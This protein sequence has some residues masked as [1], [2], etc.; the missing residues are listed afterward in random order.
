M[1]IYENKS[2]EQYS[3]KRI[4][5]EFIDF[6]RFKVENDTFT[7]GEM[8]SIA[9]AII[10][11]ADISATVDELSS[12]YGKSKDAVNGVIKRKMI[13]K[14]RRNVVLYSLSAFRK[15]IPDKWSHKIP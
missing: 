13:Q 4:L 12:F 1:Q 2:K 7:M 6:I 9:R 15:I 3:S 11:N 14:P 5:L 8:Q 10:G